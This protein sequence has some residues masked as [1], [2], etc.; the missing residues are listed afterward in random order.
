VS[1]TD[2]LLPAPPQTWSGF[3]LYKLGKLL[4]ATVWKP[5]PFQAGGHEGGRVVTYDDEGLLVARFSKAKGKVEM[6]TFRLFYTDL[7]N[8]Q[9]VPGDSISRHRLARDICTALG[10]PRR[11]FTDWERQML[12]YAAY[13]IHPSAI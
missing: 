1:E 11:T 8:D 13:L 3:D 2:D 6:H 7:D 4:G 12:G 5:N 10:V 9:T